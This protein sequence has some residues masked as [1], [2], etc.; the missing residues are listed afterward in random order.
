MMLALVVQV[1]VA[2]GVSAGEAGSDARFFGPSR[3]GDAHFLLCDGFED[4]ILDPERWSVETSEGNVAEIVDDESARGHRSVHLRAEN[5]FAFLKTQAVFPIE[6]DRYWARMFLRVERFSTVPWAHWTVAEA[7]GEGDGSLIRVGG[8]FVTTLERNRWGVGT[9]G[10]PTGDWTMHDEDPGT[11]PKEPPEGEWICLEW[12]HD[13]AQDEALFFVDGV[14]H[15]SLN[16]SRTRH[17]GESVPY[18]LPSFRSLWFGW[19]Q[20]Q[21]DREPFD[22]WIDEVAVDHNRIGCSR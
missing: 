15:P 13:G 4:D 9:D 2:S 14:H 6:G 19:W 7:A 11:G 20:Y 1:S 5:G 22:I 10:G 21:S 3:C 8:Q 18:D 17:G 12:M 16:T